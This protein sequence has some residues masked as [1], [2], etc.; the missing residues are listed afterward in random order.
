MALAMLFVV[1][2]SACSSVVAGV[3]EPSGSGASSGGA[4]DSQRTITL[5]DVRTVDV[6]GLTP[7]EALSSIG[8]VENRASISGVN[9]CQRTINI[10]VDAG[11]G[12]KR[13]VGVLDYTLTLTSPIESAEWLRKSYPTEFSQGRRGAT[14]TYQGKTADGGCMRL[15]NADQGQ[16]QVVVKKRRPETQGDAC[17]TAD[18]AFDAV[19][20]SVLSDTPIPRRP[21]V[22]NSI[23]NLD[24]CALVTP[25]MVRASYTKEL[26]ASP[27]ISVFSCAFGGPG[28]GMV[29]VKVAHM[30]VP[31]RLPL[32]PGTKVTTIAGRPATENL[33]GPRCVVELGHIATDPPADA[34]LPYLE[35]VHFHYT[36][37]I[38]DS[39]TACEQTTKL[40][41]AVAAKLPPIS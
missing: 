14:T 29:L 36:T 27:Q 15:A 23:V 28:R 13:V 7:V 10:E 3:A 39:A 34:E 12:Q 24:P 32:F 33:M 17:A 41:A 8:R 19:L 5:G 38:D 21:T 4:K 18:A 30:L 26:Q 9:S 2:S 6:C 1:M 31:G 16:L 20:A 22:A 25:E 35:S 40:A 37:Q 11:S